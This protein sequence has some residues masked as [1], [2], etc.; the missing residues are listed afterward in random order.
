MTPEHHEDRLRRWAVRTGRPVLSVEYGKAPECESPRFICAS[1]SVIHSFG[2]TDP[3]PFAI[4]EC[5]DTYRV[6]VES[7]GEIIGMS[8]L[9]SKFSVIFSGDSAYVA[10]LDRSLRLLNPYIPSFCH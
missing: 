10:C 8:G 2:S 3:Y 7:A 1:L 4:D 9:H 5:F 6:L